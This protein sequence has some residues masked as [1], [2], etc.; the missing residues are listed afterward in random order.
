MKTK[1][2]L[3]FLIFV[4]IFLSGCKKSVQSG[5]LSFE[6][7]N[8]V[9]TLRSYGSNSA[10]ANQKA[11]ERILQ[12][13]KLI[14]VTDEKSEVYMLNKRESVWVS[15]D[16][17]FLAEYSLNIAEKT[18]GAFNPVLYPVTSLWGFTQ[19]SFRVPSDKEISE[20][21]ANTDFHKVKI[22][23]N[24]HQLFLPEEMA[25]DF[26]AVGKGYAGDEAIKVLKE[27]GIES[28][29]LDLGGNVQVLGDKNGAPWKVG[30]RNPWDGDVPVVLSVKNCAVITSGGYERYFTDESG[31]RYIHIFDGRTGYPVES[32]VVSVT[33]VTDSGLYGDALSTSL[34]ILGKEKALD[35]YRSEKDF[36]FIMIFDNHS[37]CYSGG[38]KGTIELYDDFSS[39]E[40]VE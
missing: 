8:T 37:I 19:S 38:L 4:S 18:E 34:F 21:L 3:L 40:V 2:P 27:N 23:E 1:L 31:N 32:N 35:L 36:E 7:M 10:Q 26:G 22:Y 11:K 17:F 25:F 20:A 33:I 6:S 28:A 24:I 5:T 13:E 30:L 12:I 29:V 14:S 15:N 9:M 39:V 16:T